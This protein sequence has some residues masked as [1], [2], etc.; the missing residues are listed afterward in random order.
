MSEDKNAPAIN[1]DKAQGKPVGEAG[2]NS[3]AP[4]NNL[5]EKFKG[6]SPE[7][8]VEAYLNLEKQMGDQSKTVE[9]AKVLRE[10]TDTLVRAI[11]FDP[12]LYRQ[13]E[14]GVKKYTSGKSLPNREVPK[15][16]DDSPKSEVNPI[17]SDLRTNE[18]NRVL[19][20]F[21]G[22]YGYNTLDEKS[23]KDAYA[24]LSTTVA[25]LVDPSGKKSIKEIFASIPVTRLRSYLENAHFIANKDNIVQQ[26]KLSGSL[27]REENESGAIG[28]FAASNKRGSESVTLTASEREVASKMGISEEKYAKRKAQMLKDNERYE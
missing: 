10:Q 11:W 1:A 21:F 16:G 5:P 4:L 27:A 20:D 24:K 7:Q 25:E 6:K 17:I 28:S 23:R 26:A 13:V 8:I 22:K 15:K 18:E 19:N 14:A 2:N 12:D 3:Q 9:E